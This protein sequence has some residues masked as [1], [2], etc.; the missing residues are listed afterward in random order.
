[1]IGFKQQTDSGQFQREKN[2]KINKGKEFIEGYGTMRLKKKPQ[3]NT[4]P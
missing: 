1:M 3:T 4:S 2:K